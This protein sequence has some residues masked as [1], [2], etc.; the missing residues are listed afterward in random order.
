MFCEIVFLYQTRTGVWPGVFGQ[1]SM[2]GL[3]L[4]ETTIA[5]YLKSTNLNYS[6]GIIGKWHLEEIV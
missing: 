2:Y 1:S 4:N 3:P 6:T 5:Q